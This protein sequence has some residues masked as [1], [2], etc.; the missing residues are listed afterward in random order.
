MCKKTEKLAIPEFIRKKIE[1]KR[2]NRERTG[3]R[4]EKRA[5]V[6]S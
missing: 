1:E 6:N 2:K 3:K 4:R 5:W